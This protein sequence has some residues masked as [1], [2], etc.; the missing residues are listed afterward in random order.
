MNQRPL[1]QPQLTDEQREALL[2]RMAEITHQF[3]QM[4]EAV[5]PAVRAAAEQAAQVFAALQAAGLVDEDGKP[6]RPADRPA[7][8]TPYGPPQKGH[9]P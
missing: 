1:A 6:T 3:R 8:Q 2:A 9:R 7:W 5:L 4:I